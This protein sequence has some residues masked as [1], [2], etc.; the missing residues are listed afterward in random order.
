MSAVLVAGAMAGCTSSESGPKTGT[1]GASSGG[2]SAG[3]SGG[4]TGS[5]GSSDVGGTTGTGGTTGAAGT[6]GTTTAGAG[7]QGGG[8]GTAGTG[9]GGTAGAS[10]GGG[11]GTAAGQ[12]GRGGAAGRG[13][14]GGTGG[15]VGSGGAG[16]G[17]TGACAGKTYKLCDD[18]ETGNT[19]SIPPGWTALN[20]YGGDSMRGVGLATDEHHSGAMALKSSSMVPG[21]QR[22]Q[23]SL[24]ALGATATKHWGRIFYKVI[25]PSP[26]P[27]NGAVIHV[28]MA[29]LQG[30]TE[31]RVVDTVEQSNGTHQWIFNVPDDSCC[32][33]SSYNWSFDA[34]WHCAEWY[35]D[36]SAQ[37]YRFFTDGMEVTQ[38]GFTG[39]AAAKMS[40]YT[41]IGLGAIF[42]QTPPSPFT[43]WFD[44]LAIDDNQIGCN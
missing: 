36:V 25:S 32:T 29:A 17:T 24:S 37:A 20:G 40:N 7:G 35:V 9:A 38:I 34:S 2:N 31:N 28:T 44:D 26:K 11:A 41:S 15:V 8:G 19:G 12:G 22:V 6:A 27:A 10:T 5:G 33:G 42:Y 30:T 23:H 43:I 39:K 1:G 4:T 3:G 21:E 13:G 16:G 18:F 14:A